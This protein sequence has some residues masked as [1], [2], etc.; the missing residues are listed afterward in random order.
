VLGATEGLDW[1]YA[2]PAGDFGHEGSP[3]GR[4]RVHERGDAASRVTSADFAIAL[5]DE[6]DTP[7]HHREHLAVAAGLP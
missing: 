3:T 4:Y 1:L 6:I 7:R 5:L 2:S